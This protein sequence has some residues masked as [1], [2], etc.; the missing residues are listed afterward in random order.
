MRNA[1][2]KKLKGIVRQHEMCKAE[3]QRAYDN[4]KTTEDKRRA[5]ENR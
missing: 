3:L 2:Q 4:P 1:Q 5:L